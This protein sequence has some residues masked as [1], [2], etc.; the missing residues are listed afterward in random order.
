MVYISP[1]ISLRLPPLFLLPLPFS[2]RS[3]RPT[4]SESDTSACDHS[5]HDIGDPADKLQSFVFGLGG[6]A[7]ATGGPALNK[8]VICPTGP[9]FPSRHC[10]DCNG[11]GSGS[12]KFCEAR[13]FDPS[14]VAET[15]THFFST[16]HLFFLSVC[17]LRT[18]LFFLHNKVEHTTLIS[19]QFS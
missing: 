1:F 3:S 4:L 5:C 7:I 11:F 10:C 6:T 16:F 8:N 15:S 18:F 2:S 12:E 13:R 17:I 19:L 14:S 9:M